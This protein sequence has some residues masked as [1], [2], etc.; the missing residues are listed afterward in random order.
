MKKSHNFVLC[1]HL[2]TGLVRARWTAKRCNCVH[3]A[4]RKQEIQQELI[5]RLHSRDLGTNMAAKRSVSAFLRVVLWICAVMILAEEAVDAAAGNEKC[6]KWGNTFDVPLNTK[7]IV[8]DCTKP[9]DGRR[10]CCAAVNSSVAR[11]SRGVG[12]DYSYQYW[13]NHRLPS[14]QQLPPQQPQQQSQQPSTQQQQVHHGKC[15]IR[16]QYFSSPL[17]LYDIE[18]S[19]QIEN[20]TND[21]DRSKKFEALLNYVTSDE[22]HDKSVRWLNRVRAHMLQD[23]LP[24]QETQEDRDLLSYFLVTRTCGNGLVESW[25]EWIEP[26]T[27]HARHPFGFS[28]CRNTQQY[29]WKTRTGRSDAD[30]VLLQSGRALHEQTLHKQLTSSKG[31]SHRYA[32]TSPPKNNKLNNKHFMLD[33]GTSTFDSSLFWFTCAYS[34]VRVDF[35]GEFLCA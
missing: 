4:C 33:A 9:E 34:Q 1:S 21:D 25:K 14:L 16:K 19:K 3:F 10:V 6:V 11:V 28:T 8:L 5:V 15:E 17:E 32:A 18:L 13:L 35:C 24:G 26:I 29:K 31:G 30:Y 20:I 2:I 22:A 27:I 12:L 23:P 7:N